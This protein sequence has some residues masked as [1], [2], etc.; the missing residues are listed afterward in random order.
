MIGDLKER[1]R[2]NTMFLL[3]FRYDFEAA[4]RFLSSNSERCQTPHGH[5]WS[6]KVRFTSFDRQLCSNQML[7]EF[8]VLKAHW[9]TFI[10]GTVDHSFFHHVEDPLARV[11]EKEIPQ[12]RGLPFPGDPTTELI[13][14]CFFRKMIQMNRSVFGESPRVFPVAV[15]IQET[16]TNRVVLEAEDELEL[17]RSVPEFVRWSGWWEDSDPHSRIIKSAETVSRPWS[18]PLRS[19][20]EKKEERIN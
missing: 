20:S 17:I 14:V 2:A 9:K 18:L 8:S 4:H 1:L 11:M 19:S 7:E 5:S 15:E 10:Q 6:A 3:E 16:K 13:S 12:F